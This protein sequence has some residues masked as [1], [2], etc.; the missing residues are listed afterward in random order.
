MKK[1]E[2]PMLQVVSIK[3]SDII[4]AS[5]V[6]AAISGTS[7]TQLAPDRFIWDIY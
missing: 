2:N 1:F 4:T 3:K 7:D 5:D 6:D